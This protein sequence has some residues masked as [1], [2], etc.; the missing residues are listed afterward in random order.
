MPSTRTTCRGPVLFGSKEENA[1]EAYGIFKYS[2]EQQLKEENEVLH[3]IN[4]KNSVFSQVKHFRESAVRASSFARKTTNVHI[5]IARSVNMFSTLAKDWIREEKESRIQAAASTDTRHAVKPSSIGDTGQ[6]DW[7]KFLQGPITRSF[8]EINPYDKQPRTTWNMP[9]AYQ[10]LS[11]YIEQ[12]VD[13]ELLTNETWYTTTILPILQTDNIVVQWSI[14]NYGQHF[15]RDEPE[16]SAPHLISDQRT[17]YADALFSKGIGFKI[18]HGFMLTDQGLQNYRIKLLQV[19]SA[20]QEEANF[21]VI[22]ALLIAWNRVI[23][24]KQKNG[25]VDEDDLLKAIKDETLEWATVQKNEWGLRKAMNDLMKDMGERR[26]DGDSL[27]MPIEVSVYLQLAP[28]ERTH[29]NIAGERGPNLVNASVTMDGIQP[30]TNYMNHNVFITRSFNVFASGPVHLMH[31]HAQIGEYA[32]MHNSNNKMPFEKYTTADVCTA[33]YDEDRDMNVVVDFKDAAHMADIYGEDG[34]LMIPQIIHDNAYYKHD[35]VKDF[36]SVPKQTGEGADLS[37]RIPLPV[38]GMQLE[39]HMSTQFTLNAGTTL[40]NNVN[41]LYANGSRDVADIFHRGMELLERIES[42]PY[43]KDWFK[44]IQAE[45]AVSFKESTQSTPVDRSSYTL[46]TVELRADNSSGGVV[47]PSVKAQGPAVPAPALGVPAA[48]AG[49]GAAAVPTSSASSPAGMQGWTNLVAMA[50]EFRYNMVASGPGGSSVNAKGYD[51]SMLK[52]AYDY[53]SLIERM[54]NSWQQIGASF[55]TDPENT[56]PWLLKASSASALHQNLVLPRRVPWFIKLQG[57]GAG[58]VVDP[59]AKPVADP[60]SPQDT[61]KDTTIKQQID[62]FWEKFVNGPPAVGAQAAGAAAAAGGQPAAPAAQATKV[63]DD[64]KTVFARA[65]GHKNEQGKLEYANIVTGVNNINASEVRN[66]LYKAFPGA[67]AQSNLSN[68][69]A[70]AARE[71]LLYA[72]RQLQP[73]N[74][75][76]ETQSS[77]ERKQKNVNAL[78]NSLKNGYVS[79]NDAGF[80]DLAE[81]G[82][83]ASTT[84][85]PLTAMALAELVQENSSLYGGETRARKIA[86]YILSNN[87]AA[88][89][90]DAETA[91]LDANTRFSTTQIASSAGATV[92]TDQSQDGYVRS[93][94]LMSP[95]TFQ[96]WYQSGYSQG[97]PGV[98]WPASLVDPTRPATDTEIKQWI[99]LLASPLPRDMDERKQEKHLPPH[100][101]SLRSMIAA[102]ADSIYVMSTARQTDSACTFT[103]QDQAALRGSWYYQPSTPLNR[104]PPHYNM[105][106][107]AQQQ[108]YGRTDPYTGLPIVSHGGENLTPTARDNISDTLARVCVCGVFASNMHKVA[109]LATSQLQ[110]IA[111]QTYLGFSTD[112]KNLNKMLDANVLPPLNIMIARPHMRYTVAMVIR[113]MSGGRTGYFFRQKSISGV[114]DTVDTFVHFVHYRRYAKAIVYAWKNVGILPA[115][116]C[117]GREGGAGL[118]PYDYNDYNPHANEYGNGSVFYIA[119]PT[120]EDDLQDAIDISGRFEQFYQ[121]GFLSKEELAESAYNTS[122]RYNGVWGWALPDETILIETDPQVLAELS[123]VNTVMFR[124]YCVRYNRN[125]GGYSVVYEGVGHWRG[126]NGPGAQAVR[127]GHAKPTD[128]HHF[129]I[130][131]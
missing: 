55:F 100:L 72:F 4:D 50:N 13:Q 89:Q 5:G 52:Q 38:W 54:A 62:F 32:I 29:Y 117:I 92:A 88:V 35:I 47:L 77:V 129:S 86:Q 98:V 28:P 121:A 6:Y 3:F 120:S 110:R 43:K 68:N 97:S 31:R 73:R 60:Y 2:S 105:R 79:Q 22:N 96:S 125:T 66:N 11:Y 16:Q 15:L 25:F 74:V 67:F 101:R 76:V 124:G 57:D 108:M 56:E 109:E 113:C 69:Q 106:Q 7:Q 37:D 41:K 118:I 111:G 81:L 42:T 27:I 128:K 19:A 94:V 93:S 17:D 82:V 102:D 40:L 14:W 53:V 115:V 84:T 91:R 45:N 95:G 131:A 122:A 114:Q 85:R 51:T 46:G 63:G 26:G 8:K 1:R 70:N 65:F 59:L 112:Q 18:E 12:A 71:N 34:K 23:D 64:N 24:D 21:Q 58:A 80:G 30:F 39:Q 10:A 116:M 123:N 103:T 90:K 126:I 104:E 9:E 130:T 49:A 44:A 75:R 78:L 119:L 48:G 20:D 33:I 36:L 107:A 99:N 127:N 83:A 61:N 87:T